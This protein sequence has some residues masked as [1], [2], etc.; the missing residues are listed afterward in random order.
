MVNLY[1]V[2]KTC[3]DETTDTDKKDQE[4]QLLV[5]VLESVGNGLVKYT[6]FGM[7]D[8]CQ[9]KPEVQENDEQVLKLLQA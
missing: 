9:N 6:D 2:T 3:E 7:L 5:A 1:E 8:V 4:K